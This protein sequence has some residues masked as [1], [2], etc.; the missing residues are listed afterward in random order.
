MTASAST[1]RRLWAIEGPAALALAAAFGPA[2]AAFAAPAPSP[3][4][5]HLL[6]GSR[7]QVG[8]GAPMQHA[9]ARID[10]TSTEVRLA[11]CGFLPHGWAQNPRLPSRTFFFEK[12]GPGAAEFDLVEM[13]QTRVVPPVRG[14]TFYGHGAVSADARWLL[15]TESEPD[16]RGVIGVRDASTLA[17]QGEFPSHGL[18]P[19]DCHL[20]DEGRVLAVANGGGPSERDPRPCVCFIEASSGKL[21][22]R[23]EMAPGLP[24]NTGHLGPVGRDR[25]LV[26]SAP[27]RGLDAG[28][29][30]AVSWCDPRSA[31]LKVLQ[32]TASAPALLGEALSVAV[33]PE[34]DLGLVTHPTPGWISI[35][36]LSDGS[37]LG[38]LAVAR[39]RG[40]AIAASRRGLWV[41]HG[42][43]ASLGFLDLDNPGAGVRV[44]VEAAMLAGSHLL[45]QPTPAAGP[46]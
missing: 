25:A 27:Q 30:G 23:H 29:P 33:L 40:L 28:H 17:Y 20:I 26:V 2:P 46:A 37:A 32:P 42:E 4:R 22:H 8:A 38:G 44:A 19:H 1:A 9:L 5:E 21:L 6:G 24:F 45:V 16:G 10:P 3:T 13:R 39:V 31:R 7:Y 41:S 36:R 14:R 34:R 35:W 12:E 43:R 11:P 18:R 15:S